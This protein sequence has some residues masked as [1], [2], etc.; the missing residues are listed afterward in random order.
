MSGATVGERP[1]LDFNFQ[2]GVL[3]ICSNCTVKLQHLAAANERRGTAYGFG[4]Q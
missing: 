1:Q 2:Y 4:E 3:E